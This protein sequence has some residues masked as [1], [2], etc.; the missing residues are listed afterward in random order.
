MKAGTYRHVLQYVKGGHYNSMDLQAY[1][2]K[3][4]AKKQ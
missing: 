2:K 1:I 4:S 3:A